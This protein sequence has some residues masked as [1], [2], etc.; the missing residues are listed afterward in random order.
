MIYLKSAI[1]IFRVTNF[2]FT[3]TIFFGSACLFVVPTTGP[4]AQFQ[5]LLKGCKHFMKPMSTILP[6]K[7]PRKLLLKKNSVFKHMTVY[8]WILI[9]KS[10]LYFTINLLSEKLHKDSSTH[11]GR[12][13]PFSIITIQKTDPQNNNQFDVVRCQSVS[14]VSCVSWE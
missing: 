5:F 7:V 11:R 6:N 14:R 2:L 4:G 1:L 10:N 3:L 12:R 9:K 13:F 8:I